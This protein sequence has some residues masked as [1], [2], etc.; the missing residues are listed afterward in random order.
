MEP[1]ACQS[2]GED[3]LM[4]KRETSLKREFTYATL[5]MFPL[6]VLNSLTLWICQEY[7]RDNQH[8]IWESV[9]TGLSL[10]LGCYMGIIIALVI[11]YSKT[12]G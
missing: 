7:F 12:Q 5:F 2:F 4:P 10:T 8:S 1:E 9:T 3:I 6:F 11:K